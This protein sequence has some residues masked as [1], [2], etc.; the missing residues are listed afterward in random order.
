[1]YEYT[2]I[3]RIFICCNHASVKS[4]KTHLK[5]VKCS[6]HVYNRFAYSSLANRAH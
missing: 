2:F 4:I 3:E 6:E 5:P 1:M